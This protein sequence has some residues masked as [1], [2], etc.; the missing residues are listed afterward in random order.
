MGFSYIFVGWLACNVVC[1]FMGCSFG[2]AIKELA[3]N[4]Q[5]FGTFIAS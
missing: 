5:G 2:E 4:M 1:L 3:I